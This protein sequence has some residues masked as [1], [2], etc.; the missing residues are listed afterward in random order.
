M[1]RIG[2]HVLVAFVYGV[3]SGRFV[4]SPLAAGPWDPSSQHGGP[5]SAL[6]AH[7]MERHEPGWSDAEGRVM[8]A[9]VTTEIMRPVPIGQALEVEVEVVQA[10]RRTHRL[11]ATM[12]AAG[13]QVARASGLRVPRIPVDLP[14]GLDMGDHEPTPPGPEAPWARP[15][16]M[17]GDPDWGRASGR[18]LDSW[19]SFFDACEV[20]VVEGPR[21][22]PDGRLGGDPG[23]DVGRGRRCR[24]G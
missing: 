5:P 15:E 13:K 1:G 23:A 22:L 12:H 21:P 14:P 24:G 8:L 7:A 19:S 9:R 2:H 4:A 11:E 3:E 16:W 10:G 17:T 6:L 20:R 18:D